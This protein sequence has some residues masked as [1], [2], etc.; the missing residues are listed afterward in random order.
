MLRRIVFRRDAALAVLF[1]LEIALISAL[2]P[3]YFDINGIFYASQGFFEGG[4]IALGM[5]L[6]IISGGI[7][8]SVGSLLALVVV[9]IGFSY[10][11]GVPMPVAMVLGVLVG[12]AGGALNGALITQLRLNPLVVTLGT[13]AL[14]RGIALAVSNAKAVSSFPE[15][16]QF[17]GQGTLG[18]LPFQMIIFVIMVISFTFLLG[19]TVFGRHVYSVGANEQASRFSGVSPERIRLAVYTLQGALVGIAGNVYCARIS[20]ARGNEGFG[21]EFLVIT[22]V[23]F[24]GTR[25]AGGSGTILGTVIGGLVLWYLQ[26]GL[27]FAGFTS[28]WGLLITGT[29]LIAGV[30]TNEALNRLHGARS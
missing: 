7:D 1:L 17:I 18:P 10:D 11:A 13:L 20:S 26:D 25:I 3:G 12:I 9:T 19:A 28:D 29:F 5:T 14:F 24:G 27:S 23:I 2:M 6:V 30:L 4:I 15:W 16:F 21:L 8:I 22:M